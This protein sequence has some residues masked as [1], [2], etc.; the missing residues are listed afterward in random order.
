MSASRKIWIILFLLIGLYGCVSRAGVAE[1][2]AYKSVFDDSAAV[3]TAIID[4]LAVSERV[5]ERRVR[6]EPNSVG[7]DVVFR[8]DDAAIFSD[9]AD[10]PLAAQYRRAL[11]LVNQYN[12]L[13]LGYATGQG[14]AQLESEILG[15]A[16]EAGA[17]A[18]VITGS[19]NLVQ[20]LSPY[21]GV[22]EEMAEFALAARSRA[23]FRERALLYHDDIIGI[24][25]TMRDG[26]AEIFPNL[27]YSIK[28]EIVNAVGEGRPIGPL[29]EKHEKVR[30]LL[31]DWV[32]MMNKNISALN[33]VKIAVE[34]PSLSTRLAGTTAE[35]I[36]LRSVV[37]GVRK[38]LAELNAQ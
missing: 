29:R 2:T 32:V 14:F 27:T 15:F 5:V 8:P 20:G 23:V 26:S 16:R 21:L 11:A 31:S 28:S 36:E 35:I 7:I 34:N 30:V 1:F 18:E 9:L 12:K 4:Q 33:A 25:E 10:P 13:M 37:D 3:T 38:H 22:L 24:L 17:T 6:L 19:A